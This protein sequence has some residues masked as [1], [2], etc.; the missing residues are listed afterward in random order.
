MS[1]TVNILVEKRNRFLLFSL[2]SLL[3]SLRLFSFYSFTLQFIMEFGS[4]RFKKN[5]TYILIFQ[6]NDS[7]VVFGNFLLLILLEYY[8]KKLFKIE[9]LR[10]NKL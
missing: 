1:K 10:H 3:K 4:S 2:S 6:P 8:L 5:H 9:I 7:T